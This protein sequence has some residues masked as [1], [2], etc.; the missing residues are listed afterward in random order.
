MGL[1]CGWVGEDRVELTDVG[2]AQT[3]RIGFII[4]QKLFFSAKQIQK[5]PENVLSM[6]TFQEIPEIDW[7]M[8]NPNKV[9][10]AHEKKFRA[11]E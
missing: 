9:F 8:N 3:D 7:S 1:A 11:F 4:F 2:W 10:G 5:S 6:K